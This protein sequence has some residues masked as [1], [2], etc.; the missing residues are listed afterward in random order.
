MTSPDAAERTVI[1]IHLNLDHFGAGRD[2]G[3]QRACMEWLLG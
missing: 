3:V 2:A 1:R